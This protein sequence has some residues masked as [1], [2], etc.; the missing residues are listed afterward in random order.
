MSVAVNYEDVL[1]Q[2]EAAGLLL[3]GAG[4]PGIVA[5]TVAPVRCKVQGKVGKPGWYKLFTLESG[6][7]STLL[8][9]AYGVY[10]GDDP[11]T[12]KILLA[13][14]QRKQLTAD[15]LAALRLRQESD[16]RA[17]AAQLAAR[18]ERA[19]RQASRWWRKLLVSGDSQYLQR[20]GLPRGRLYGA[21]L[22]PSGNLV[23]PMQDYTGKIWGLQVIYSD[24]RIKERKGR[25]K[26][27]T[28]PGLA[29]SGHFF[30]IGGF[31][32][33]GVALICEGFATAA[34]LTEALGLP[35][36][37][38]FTAGN[39][40]AVAREIT[41]RYRGLRLLFCADDDYDWQQNGKR[42]TGVES[43]RTAALAV[44]GGVC[45][46]DFPVERPVITHKGPTDFN[47]LHVHPDGGLHAVR[48]QVQASLS[49]LGWSFRGAQAVRA[50]D[51]ERGGGGRP[52]L[53]GGV[54]ID[55][56]VERWA[57]IYGAKDSLFDFDEHCLVPKSNVLDLLPEHAW[58]DWKQCNM[59]VYRLD[60][61]GFDP[62]GH[63]MTVKCNLWGGWPTVPK[64][65]V[66]DQLLD[67][68]RYLCSKE[69]DPDV[70]F[71]WIVRWLAY[72]IQHPG[73]KMRSA[74]VFHGDVGAGK[75]LIFETIMDIYGEYGAV[76]DQSAIEDKFNDYA[77]RKLFLVADEVVARADLWHVKNKLKGFITG[78]WIR[79]NPK[80]VAAH[81]ERNHVNMVF[82]SNEDQ[83]TVIERGDRRYC[84]VHTP[85][86][87][88]AGYYELCRQELAKGG[89]EALHYY[90]L[91]Y[92]LGDF[93]EHSKPPLTDA[94]KHVQQLSAS[95][96]ERFW[97]E[98][99]AGETRHPVCVCG[100]SQLF[101]A[102]TRWCVRNGE[103]ARTQN[104]LS[105]FINHRVG[106]QIALK[107][108]YE[109]ANYG[110]ETLRS[111]TVVPPE[112]LLCRPD[113]RAEDYRKSPDK[114]ESQWITD[115]WFA[116]EESFSEL[117]DDA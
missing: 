97:E 28:P 29:Q 56:A 65:G 32:P 114:T 117:A 3:F 113:I 72:P 82:L 38:A 91:N 94:K 57:L 70:L 58:R 25:D 80:Q 18:H 109:R 44:S 79:I 4:N 47:D 68:L 75:N 110:G 108:H 48:A 36:V 63:D 86:A 35:V 73:A 60:E 115:S 76:I 27:F 64:E 98:W 81:N 23:I 59:K 99:L 1:G 61:V 19:A 9:G 20:K 53:R 112:H 11:G 7:G 83:P 5:D 54:T 52:P 41:A 51:S 8:V 31:Q 66:C 49:A 33:G 40:L 17:A 88:S 39:L 13:T 96:I 37:V 46:P 93:H 104:H 55:E 34:S 69:T 85:D 101:R 12:Q 67:L 92:P 87:L 102:Y 26:D 95:S 10:Q 50:E 71:E 74:L 111:R 105:G 103:K 100:S 43:A 77:S 6:G 62:T 24:P 106:W 78:Q 42:N 30:L 14:S 22:S 45:V 90:L 84:V 21:R 116:F 2:L 89:R 15:Q 107:H 16:R